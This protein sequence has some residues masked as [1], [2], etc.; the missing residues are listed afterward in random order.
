MNVAAAPPRALSPASAQAAGT[1]FMS[2]SESAS[3]PSIAPIAFASRASNQQRICTEHPNRLQ[4]VSVLE[5]PTRTNVGQFVGAAAEGGVEFGAIASA[6]AL[7]PPFRVRCR[8]TRRSR[9]TAP[10]PNS[11]IERTSSGKLRLP[12]AAAHVKR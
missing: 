4:S 5:A 11:S 1:L 9:A 6:V 3:A 8:G 7:S 2:M 12:E 10:W